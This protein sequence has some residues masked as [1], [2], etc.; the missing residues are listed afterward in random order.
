MGKPAS[1]IKKKED[2]KS[3]ISKGWISMSDMV[4]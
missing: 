3:P 2:H 1:A 4:E